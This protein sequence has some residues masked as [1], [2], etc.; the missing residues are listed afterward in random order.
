MKTQFDFI[1]WKKYAFTISIIVIVISGWFILGPKSMDVGVMT[2]KFFNLGIDFQGGLVMRI[3]VY[4]GISIEEI[5]QFASESELGDNVQ[6]VIDENSKVTSSEK[7][8]LIKT[9]LTDKQQ[10]SISDL[11]ESGGDVT[12]ASFLSEKIDEFFSKIKTAKGE[13][14]T[15]SEEELSGVDISNLDHIDN[16]R[17]TDDK[18]ILSNIVTESE[19]LVSPSFSKGQRDKAIGLIAFV[20]AIILLYITLRFKFENAIGAVLALFH[21]TVIML[22]V[23]SIFNIELDLTV[24]AAILT[25][26]GYSINDTIVVFDRIRENQS[27]MKGSLPLDVFNTSINQSLNRTIITSLTTLLAVVSLYIFGSQMIKGFSF[28]V[29]IG[30]LV[31]TYSSIF[32]ASPVVYIW[33]R[34]LSKNK[35]KYAKMEQKKEKDLE[36]QEKKA[37][38]SKDKVIKDE[39]LIEETKVSKKMLKKLQNQKKK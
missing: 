37:E 22:G 13:F 26:I 8:F 38:E 31:G 29:M 16:E 28:T 36:K 18:V 27:I 10:K 17:S 21:D 33:E 30:I 25:I 15:M 12:T 9:I 1:K 39:V 11:K 4:S 34:Q 7:S 3:K 14:Y 24:I 20:L 32:V 2:P 5:R 19:N 23:I 6:E 35:D